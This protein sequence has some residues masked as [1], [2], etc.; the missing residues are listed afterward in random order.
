[1]SLTTPQKIHWHRESNQLELVYGSESFS[2]EAEFLRVHSTSAEVK[3]H[4]PGQE[5]LVDGKIDVAIKKIEPVGNYGLKILF[6]DGHDT[7]I[8]TWAYLQALGQQKQQYWQAYLDKLVNE[9]KTR[10][11]HTNVIHFP[12]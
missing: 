1:M 7:G 5:V 8:Y 12:Q 11:P 2:F 3:G 4:G 6:D 9:N 10:D